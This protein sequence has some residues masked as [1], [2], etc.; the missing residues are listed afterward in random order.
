MF[1]PIYY[2]GNKTKYTI[3]EY[4]V[5][6][7]GKG[8]EMSPFEINSGYMGI[9]LSYHD[10]RFSRTIHRL[11]A[12]CFIGKIP[13]GYV[14]NHIDGNKHNNYVGNL[15]IIPFIENVRKAY[16]LGLVK[17]AED[18]FRSTHTNDQIEKVCELI[19]TNA[20]ST[21]EIS[22]MTGVNKK[23]IN[24]LRRKEKWKSI[25]NKFD[26][27]SDKICRIRIIQ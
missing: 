23:L 9:R 27:P 3:N 12:E 20:F 18:C 8:H 21:K 5:I 11:V 17:V 25:C 4:G 19:A 7:N 10:K 2:N 13:E 22:K 16:E 6:L 24:Q 26:F 14:V 15:E 1:K